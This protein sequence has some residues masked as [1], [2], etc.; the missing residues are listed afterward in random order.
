MAN[1]VR[2]PR[3]YPDAI[4]PDLATNTVAKFTVDLAAM[5]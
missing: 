5:R 3:S 4:L 1:V 2:D